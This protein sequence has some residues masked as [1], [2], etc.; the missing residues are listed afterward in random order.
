MT[1]GTRA[2]WESTQDGLCDDRAARGG[3]PRKG[4]AQA[5]ILSVPSFLEV[6]PTSLVTPSL[7]LLVVTAV[8]WLRTPLLG[9]VSSLQTRSK[10]DLSMLIKAIS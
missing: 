2:P 7:I 3:R 9:K 1:A 10:P 5:P 4:P 8:L 6:H